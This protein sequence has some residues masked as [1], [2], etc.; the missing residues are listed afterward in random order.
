MR[1]LLMTRSPYQTNG[2][3]STSRSHCIIHEIDRSLLSDPVANSDEDELFVGRGCFGIVKVQLYRGIHV[4]VKEFLPKTVTA[5]VMHEASMLSCMCHPHLPLLFGVCI[6]QR[7][8]CIVM[9]FHAFEG[10]QPSTLHRELQHKHFNTFAWI[11][12]CAQVVEAI[13]YLHGSLHILHNDIKTD[14][15]LVTK[16]QESPHIILIDF[17]KATEIA[18]AKRYIPS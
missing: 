11:A 9:Q 17:G 3:S 14:N 18:K 13:S 5:D 8:L 6:K 16:V 10:L 12:M 1:S 7:P 4:A 15:V 2:E